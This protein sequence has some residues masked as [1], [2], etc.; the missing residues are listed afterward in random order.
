MKIN[1][2]VTDTELIFNQDQHIVSSTTDKGV[3]TFVNDDFMSIS[4]FQSDELIGQAHN[5][6]R[7]PDMPQAA[8]KELWDTTKKHQPWMGVVKNRCKNG[9]YYWVDAFVTPMVTDGEVSGFQSVRLKP[10]RTIVARADKLYTKFKN[11]LSWLDKLRGMWF[12]L[13]TKM[14]LAG[15]ASVLAGLIIGSLLGLTISAEV[16]ALVVVTTTSFSIFSFCMSRPWRKAAM[17]NKNIIDSPLARNIYTGR[18]DELGQLLLTIEFLKAQQNTVLWRTMTETDELHNAAMTAENLTQSAESNMNALHGEVDMVATAMEEMTATV[19]E[20]AESASRTSL[21]TQEAYDQANSG[22][23]ALLE[24]RQI[25]GKLA[26]ELDRCSQIIQKLA[27][28]SEQIGSVVD[29]I[30]GVAEQTNLLALNAAIE[31]ARA[32]EMGRG[33][34]VVADEVR[35]LAGKTQSSTEEINTMILALQQA[36][37]DA[38]M[39]MNDSSATVGGCLTK[40]DE[41]VTAFNGVVS[42]VDMINDM[43]TQI[44]TATEEQTLVCA[45][46]NQNI[47]NINTGASASVESCESIKVASGTLLESVKKLNVMILQFSR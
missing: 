11:G 22:K 14:M 30:R 36:A 47:I 2:P 12:S 44:A 42:S 18:N 41:S 24:T 31:A 43:S 34:A 4:G 3:L 9:N 39:A 20:V 13:Q 28:D 37:Q 38:V 8:F 5:I 33:F 17:T 15:F 45:E 1:L 21:S 10:S 6:V 25:I 32:G 29:V 19:Q 26:V 46:I 27:A 7:H 23:N 40:A 16:I 35:G